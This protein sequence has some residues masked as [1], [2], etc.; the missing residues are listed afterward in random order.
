[1][2]LK[3]RHGEVLKRED[4]SIW[5]A[6]ALVIIPTV[7]VVTVGLCLKSGI[8][9]ADFKETRILGVKYTGGLPVDSSPDDLDSEI[10]DFCYE[11]DLFSGLPVDDCLDSFDGARFIFRKPWSSY[12]PKREIAGDMVGETLANRTIML[13]TRFPEQPN[14]TTLKDTAL[15][16]E[17]VHYVFY[18]AQH[19]DP[20]AT[21]RPECGW[22]VEIDQFVAGLRK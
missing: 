21:H 8:G 11:Y 13:A 15:H 18:Y 14:K 2:R 16:H 6:L 1:M 4:I 9:K 12:T 7:L 19:G 20:C 10:K 17:L 5:T 22:T 3:N